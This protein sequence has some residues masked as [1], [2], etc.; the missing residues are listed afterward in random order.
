MPATYRSSG[1]EP[2]STLLAEAIANQARQEDS[3]TLGLFD[4]ADFAG[5]KLW[6]WCTYD[7][8]RKKEDVRPARSS[9]DERTTDPGTT[10]QGGD[11]PGSPQEVR[12][13]GWPA[14]FH[15]G[16]LGSSKANRWDEGI[17]E[18]AQRPNGS[19]EAVAAANAGS[20][21]TNWSRSPPCTPLS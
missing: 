18:L 7:A 1:T 8:R 9:Q 6:V 16:S 15:P 4:P 2:D 13:L 11:S 20:G 10:G 3:L 17:S 21:R 14:D 5:P 12:R 19:I